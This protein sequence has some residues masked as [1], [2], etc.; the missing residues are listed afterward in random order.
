MP[1][2]DFPRSRRNRSSMHSLRPKIT[3]LVWGC[4][5]AVR[6]SRRMAAACGPV[7]LRGAV[8]RFSSPCP[9]R[10]RPY[11]D[12]PSYS[13]VVANL[14]SEKDPNL[15]PHFGNGNS[16]ALPLILGQSR[17]IRNQQFLKLALMGCSPISR[18]PKP[19]PL[20]NCFLFWLGQNGLTG[21]RNARRRLVIQVVDG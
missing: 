3:G 16:V 2:W 7:A 17:A 6:S 8:Q 15:P 20:G 14:L 11:V 4:P 12:L 19:A 5:S 13:D 18:G 10:S 9:L 1:V 21:A